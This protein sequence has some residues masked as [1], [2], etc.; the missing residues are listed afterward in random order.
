[1]KKIVL[2]LVVLGVSVL[3]VKIFEGEMRD[4]KNSAEQLQLK[5]SATNANIK[6]TL[7][8][9]DLGRPNKECHK[10][11]AGIEFCKKDLGTCGVVAE[12]I[13]EAIK[14]LNQ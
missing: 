11:N 3:C 6:Y 8:C 9:Y 7:E 14:L 1:M 4:A 13:T 10:F 12:R 2:I 5:M